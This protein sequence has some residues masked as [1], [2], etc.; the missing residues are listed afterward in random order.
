[1]PK[2]KEIGPR[3]P[4]GTNDPKRGWLPRLGKNQ[5]PVVTQVVTI[6]HTPKIPKG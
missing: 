2:H 1:M 5:G 4:V 6:V 3:V